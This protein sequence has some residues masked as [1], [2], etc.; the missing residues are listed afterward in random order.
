MDHDRLRQI[1]VI[2]RRVYSLPA[3]DTPS[4]SGDI[5]LTDILLALDSPELRDILCEIKALQRDQLQRLERLLSRHA[6]NDS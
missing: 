6:D 3:S 4:L 2:L 1:A 5:L